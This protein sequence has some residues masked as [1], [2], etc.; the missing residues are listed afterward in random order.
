[1]GYYLTVIRM[2]VIINIQTDSEEAVEKR[3]PSCTVGG[4]VN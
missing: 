2:A 3:E 4:N 1:M